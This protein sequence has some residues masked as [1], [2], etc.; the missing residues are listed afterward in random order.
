MF[1]PESNQPQ[2]TPTLSDVMDIS[3]THLWDTYIMPHIDKT[4]LEEIEMVTMIGSILR[5]AQEKATA[6]D[7]LQ[8]KKDYFSKN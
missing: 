3:M 7:K 2:N 4:D 5:E 1:I 8:S 6:Y